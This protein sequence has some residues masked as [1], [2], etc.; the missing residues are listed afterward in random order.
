MEVSAE[1]EKC[2][3]SRE[4][5]AEHLYLQFDNIGWETIIWLLCKGIIEGRKVNSKVFLGETSIYVS[6][7][8]KKKEDVRILWI[9]EKYI[10]WTV[11]T[12]CIEKETKWPGNYNAT[13][14]FI[15][16]RLLR[17]TSAKNQLKFMS[18]KHLGL[19]KRAMIPLSKNKMSYFRWTNI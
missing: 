13:L 9:I 16:C 8:Q 14:S 1:Q 5:W 4:G 10:L 7:Q 18:K 15:L 19:S 6:I 3:M 17:R 11:S 2:H 12:C